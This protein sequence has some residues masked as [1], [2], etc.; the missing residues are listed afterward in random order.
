MLTRVL[1]TVR[2][3]VVDQRSQAGV[4]L[5]RVREDLRSQLADP[6][7]AELILIE[8]AAKAALITRAVGEYLL[9]QGSLAR[10]S[11]ELLPAVA[12]HAQLQ[13]T[14][15]KLLTTLGLKRKAKD[16]D[17]AA[18]FARLHKEAGD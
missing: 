11:G 10:E 3:D 7:P 4:F 13:A 15:V 18:A 16:L 1:R 8:E 5:R 12:Q 14:L 6:S 9:S 2:L 17:V